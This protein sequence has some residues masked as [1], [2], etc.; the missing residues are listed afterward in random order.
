MKQ[1]AV[2]PVSKGLYV[3]G[4]IGGFLGMIAIAV[5][6]G[7]LSALAGGG[8][9]NDDLFPL[10][11]LFALSPLLI[12]I[13]LYFMLVYR[14]WATLRE[15]SASPRT[16][17]G[18][19]VG[20]SFVPIWHLYWKFVVIYV[21]AKEYNLAVAR[22]NLQAP[23]MPEGIALTICILPLIT[24]VYD[25]VGILSIVD[26]ILTAIFMSNACDGINA[27]AAGVPRFVDEEEEGDQSAEWQ[28]PRNDPDDPRFSADKP[29]GY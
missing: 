4:F 5:A 10:L 16:G 1:P 6:G 12:S 3:G 23:R 17:P 14:M 24:C 15:V 18:L 8:R 20:L 25:P 27:I 7:V 11:L 22:R 13:V 2:Q 28:A 26:L 19:A 21:W 29:L 9:S